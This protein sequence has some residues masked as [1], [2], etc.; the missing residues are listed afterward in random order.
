MINMDYQAFKRFRNTLAEDLLALDDL[1][2]YPVFEKIKSLS[3]L[4]ISVANPGDHY[5]PGKGVRDLLKRL[6]AQFNNHAL[7]IILPADIYP[8]YQ[9]LAA[10]IPWVEFDTFQKQHW[11]LPNT[12]RAVALITHPITPQSEYISQSIL[13]QLDEWLESGK[14]R[15]LLV[16]EVYDIL[17]KSRSY[18]FASDRVIYVGSLSKI[19]L[20]PGKQGWAVSRSRFFAAEQTRN[21][22]I[23]QSYANHLQELYAK[24]WSE[25]SARLISFDANWL[26]PQFGYLSVINAAHEKLLSHGIVALPASVFGICRSDSC[27]VSCLSWLKQ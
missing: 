25:L 2:P 16:D 12:N 22:I 13:R 14:E 26:A 11:M 20:N 23:V 10:G 4:E 24:A 21:P 27:V 18:R 1:N 7:Q 15:W 17:N 8:V 19:A 6:F 5:L 9:Q 3:P